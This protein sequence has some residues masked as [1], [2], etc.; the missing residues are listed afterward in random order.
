MKNKRSSLLSNTIQWN[1]RTGL[2]NNCTY[3]IHIKVIVVREWPPVSTNMRCTR[4]YRHFQISWFSTLSSRSILLCFSIIFFLFFFFFLF[5]KFNLEN[6]LMLSKNNTYS[7][8]FFVYSIWRF[9]FWEWY[10][11]I[12]KHEYDISSQ[13]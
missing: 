4:T 11:T 13:N 6:C 10:N 3:N 1:E 7:K 12:I 8:I 9:L 2:N 5:I